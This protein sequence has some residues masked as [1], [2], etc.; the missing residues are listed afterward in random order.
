MACVLTDDKTLSH[1][2]GNSYVAASLSNAVYGSCSLRGIAG[3]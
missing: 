1:F 2:W 3:E